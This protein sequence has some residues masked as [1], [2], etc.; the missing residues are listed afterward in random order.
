MQ[1]HGDFG[2]G[3][4]ADLD[5]EMVSIDG[6]EYQIT[7]DGKVHK[8]SPNTLLSYA[9]VTHFTPDRSAKLP[10]NSSFATI[11]SAVLGD[12][13]ST[14]AFY[15]I[16]LSGTFAAVETRAVPRQKI[17]YPPFC[18]VTKTQPTFHFTEVAGTMAGFIGPASLSTLD[19]S[20]LHL[21]FLTRDGQA[22]GHVLA[23]TAKDVT[24]ELERIDQM[25]VDFPRD[26]AFEKTSLT[27]IVTCR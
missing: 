12:D 1:Q 11:V 16:R 23:L 17:P 2:L 27:Q 22:G 20:G 19:T 15:A 3:A 6:T 24:A 4:F 18:E 13:A 8:P 7:S 10:V 14:S 21:H 5:G 26:P 25:Q 9:L